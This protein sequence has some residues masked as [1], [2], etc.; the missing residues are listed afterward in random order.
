MTKT[1]D[2]NR[3]YYAMM[4]ENDDGFIHDPDSETDV[5]AL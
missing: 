5:M 2:S 1:P 3:L 4:T